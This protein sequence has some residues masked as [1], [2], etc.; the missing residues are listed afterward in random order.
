MCYWIAQWL[1]FL[2]LC[3]PREVK[4]RR[5]GNVLHVEFRRRP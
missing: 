1:F 3:F 4:V 5:E 2:D